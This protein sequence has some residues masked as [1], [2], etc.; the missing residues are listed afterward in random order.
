[1]IRKEQ[2]REQ[3]KR[4]VSRHQLKEHPP[5]VCRDC[6]EPRPQAHAYPA[7]ES[8]RPKTERAGIDHGGHGDQLLLG[9]RCP[10]SAASTFLTLC[11]ASSG[12][13]LIVSLECLAG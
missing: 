11:P 4:P 5:A 13:S 12:I 6:P 9:V 2:P 1:M 10:L 7:A 3:R 8:R